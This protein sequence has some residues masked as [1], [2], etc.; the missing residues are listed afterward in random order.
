MKFCYHDRSGDAEIVVSD[1]LFLHL[2]KAR[3]TKIDSVIC[4]RNLRDENLYFYKHKEIGKKSAILSLIKFE[5][6]QVNSK[7][8]HLVWA[9]T[10]SKNI[11]K[12]LPYLNQLGVKKLTLFF[13]NRSQRHEKLSLERLHKILIAS[14]EQCGRSHLMEIELLKNTKEV[15]EKYPLCQ[16]LN[17]GGCDIHAGERSFVH[18][19]MIGPEGGFDEKEE[20]M[21]F[22]REVFSV[23]GGIVLKSE[24][25]AM[26]VG[27]LAAI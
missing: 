1:N 13:A 6:S 4:F 9:I 15:L 10:E 5:K 24:C 17:F 2:Y 27:S 22:D 11:E 8:T 23:S 25:A 16:I 7:Q 26:L 19:I 12:T 14:C 20:E 21:F 3:R 18:G